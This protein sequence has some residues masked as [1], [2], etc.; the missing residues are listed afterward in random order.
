MIIGISIG[1]AVLLIAALVYTYYFRLAFARKKPK[2]GMFSF[3]GSNDE[4]HKRK[5]KE[6]YAN[7]RN[8]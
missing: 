6:R 5:I 8:T 3:A 1:A 2:I 7:W 4:E